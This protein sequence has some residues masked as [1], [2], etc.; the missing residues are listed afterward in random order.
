M[1]RAELWPGA[2][3]C[4]R[5]QRGRSAINSLLI[6][7][8][9]RDVLHYHGRH[10]MYRQCCG[11]A[12]WRLRWQWDGDWSE[13]GE[14]TDCDGWMSVMIPSTHCVADAAH[15]WYDQLYVSKV[16]VTCRTQVRN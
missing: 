6:S 14:N 12:H 2:A 3:S 9:P 5:M 13:G 15:I 8:A 11:Y 16:G 10:S 7:S 4:F 1:H